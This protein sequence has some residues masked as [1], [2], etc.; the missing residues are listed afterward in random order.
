MNSCDVSADNVF[1]PRVDSCRDG[2]DF[3]L[4]FEQ[5]IF[6]AIPSAAVIVASTG[7]IVYLSRQ[8][9]KTKTGA[10]KLFPR[11]LK[12]VSCLLVVHIACSAVSSKC[13]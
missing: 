3:T 1:G 12:Q 8:D 6:S 13:F 5:T 4:L 9:V 2:F 7:C 10:T 11:L